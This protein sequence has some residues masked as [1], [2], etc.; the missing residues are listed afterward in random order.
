MGNYRFNG[1]PTVQYNDSLLTDLTNNLT[2][3]WTEG[4][5]FFIDYHI[6]DGDTPENICY[7]L[8]KDSSLSWIIDYV[9]GVIDPFFDWPL[10]SDELMDYVKEKY[11]EDNV[12]NVHHYTKNGYIVSTNPS[13]KSLIPVSNYKYEFD[14]NEEKRD[15]ILPTERFIQEFL[16]KWG[17][18]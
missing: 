6:L 5:T 4:N 15:I 16:N 1:V 9:N 12:Y 11:G 10:R 7:R 14:L 13:D 18:E 3:T 8:W 17:E 2:I